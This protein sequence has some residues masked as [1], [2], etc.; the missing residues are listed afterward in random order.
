MRLAPTADCYDGRAAPSRTEF[1]SVRVANEKGYSTLPSGLTQAVEHVLVVLGAMP[2]DPR[3]DIHVERT[4]A[5]GDCFVE[6]IA[7]LVH[8][9]SL[10]KRR[11]EPAIDQREVRIETDHLSRG[12]DGRLVVVGEIMR[13]RDAIEMPRK[14]RVARVEPDAGLKSDE[15]LLRFT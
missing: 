3:A 6:R 9:S 8:A 7:R 4:A 12:I 1:S 2:R 15:P 11:G 10:A 5:D 13:N 14:Q